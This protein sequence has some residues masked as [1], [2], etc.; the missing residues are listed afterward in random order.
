MRTRG[1]EGESD[2]GEGISLPSSYGRLWVPITRLGPHL[3]RFDV[4]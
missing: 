2:F 1:E 3:L 4:L